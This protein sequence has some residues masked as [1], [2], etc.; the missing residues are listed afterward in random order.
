MM[1][2]VTEDR[3]TEVTRQ[4]RA[5]RHRVYSALLD[6]EQV[7]QWRF[8]SEM[9]CEVH[10]FEP[11][12]GG[13]V[14]ISLTYDSPDRQGKTTGQTD[15]YRG[16]FADLVP[17]A[18][19]VEVDEFETSDPQLA[20]EMTS[21]IRLADAPDGGTLLS[22][23]HVGLPPGVSEEDNEAGWQEALD[24]LADLVAGDG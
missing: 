20:G 5:P 8:P 21:V 15:T 7:A 17:D 24:R 11:H 23:A 16:R 2:G 3:R 9:R 14:R 10:E 4:L 22:A 1:P 13:R 18:L 6:P 19:V 12:I